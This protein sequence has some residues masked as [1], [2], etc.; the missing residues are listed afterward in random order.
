[1]NREANTKLFTSIGRVDRS[2]G[3]HGEFKILFDFD[4]PE[5]LD[6]LTV[7]YLRNERGDYFPVRISKTRV[8]EKGKTISF[9]V[10]F[11]HIADRTSAEEL[12]GKAVFIET[13]KAKAILSSQEEHSFLHYD[14]YNSEGL[15]VGTV[16]DVMENPAQ[17]ILNVSSEK[18]SL[19]IPFV[20]H[21]VIE[22]DEA[23]KSITCRNLDELEGL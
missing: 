2:H 11:E 14:V 20:N 19:L 21:F 13:D 8:Q 1:M 7:L 15:H 4:A 5:I 16:M 12:K 23:V 3:L 17:T 18:G 6:E 22:T 9:F 10:Q